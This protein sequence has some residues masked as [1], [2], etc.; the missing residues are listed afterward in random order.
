MGRSASERERV[1]ELAAA[2]K[3][4]RGDLEGK[5]PPGSRDVWKLR[6]NKSWF[7]MLPD[8]IFNKINISC[9]LQAKLDGATSERLASRL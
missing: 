5:R 6:T 2:S 3:L 4:S 7:K 1:R 9:Q 8:C